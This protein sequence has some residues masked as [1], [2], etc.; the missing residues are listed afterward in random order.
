MNNMGGYIIYGSTLLYITTNDLA[1][2]QCLGS[3]AAVLA[4]YSM[5]CYLAEWHTVRITVLA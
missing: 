2:V 3:R 5:Y 1:R 4:C